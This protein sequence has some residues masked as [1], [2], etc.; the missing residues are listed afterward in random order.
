MKTKPRKTSAFLGIF[1]PAHEF[2]QP[3]ARKLI[4]VEHYDNLTRILVQYRDAGL[5]EVLGVQ[6]AIFSAISMSWLFNHSQTTESLYREFASW[7]EKQFAE[8]IRKMFHTHGDQLWFMYYERIKEDLLAPH[9][10]WDRQRFLWIAS[11]NVPF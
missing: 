10:V 3:D 6:N 8:D 5:G 7:Q 11:D 9:L 1:D 4:R 2:E